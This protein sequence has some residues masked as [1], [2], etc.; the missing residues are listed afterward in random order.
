MALINKTRELLANNIIYWRLKNNW[1]QEEFAYKINSSAQYV[2]QME[3]C[4]R[5]ITS[6]T[7]DHL[8]NIFNIEPHELLIKRPNVKGKRATVK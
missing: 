5:N 4:K 2:S 1:S 3:N 7:I 8:A 6:D